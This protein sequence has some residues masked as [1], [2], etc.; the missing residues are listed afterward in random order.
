MAQLTMVKCRCKVQIGGLVAGT[1]CDYTNHVLSF[2]VDKNRGQA[3]TCSVSMRVKK[4]DASLANS[5]GEI[6]ISAG[7]DGYLPTIF[8]GYLKSITI[9]PCREYPS[10]IIMNVTGVD[11][12]SKLEGK[13]YTR[14]CRSVMSTWVSIEGV[15]REGIRTGKLLWLPNDTYL[16]F[17]GGK[18][19][20]QNPITRTRGISFPT[21]FEKLTT[22]IN[23]QTPIMV[24][25]YVDSP[26]A[27]GTTGQ[28]QP[29]Q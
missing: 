29:S 13:K 21:A 5:R 16:E 20:K 8:Y 11:V 22:N 1:P 23:E 28:T 14:R 12:L 6:I 7:A 27:Q 3:G 25:A 4:G 18:L 15:V 26:T 10:Y 19:N 2:N 9:S 17:D 24:Y